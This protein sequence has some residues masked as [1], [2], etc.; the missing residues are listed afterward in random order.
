MTSDPL[1]FFT[2]D[3]GTASTAAALIA[4][5]GGRFRLLASSA[6]PRGLS[7]ETLLEDLVDRVRAAEPDALPDADEWP[8]WARLEVAT[9][10]P[11]RVIVA[12][13]TEAIAD[14]LVRTFRAT[15]WE[16][17]ARFVGG[18]VDP[19]AITRACL[20]RDVSVVV[21]G[22][23]EPANATIRP[24][25]ARLAAA[26]GAAAHRR[27]GLHAILSGGAAAHSEAFPPARVMA[28]PAPDRGHDAGD[29]SLET[30]AAASTTR[31]SPAR[32]RPLPDGR[33]GFA[34]A[35]TSLASLLDRPI[36]ALD[37]GHSAGTR[38]QA[39]P[40]GRRDVHID[41]EAALIPRK[42]MAADSDIDA[43][44][45]WTALRSEHFGM[46]DRLRNLRLAPWRE[47]SDDAARLR[48]AAL[49]SS[50]STLVGHPA[51][52][53]RTGHIAPSTH[54]A[55]AGRSGHA[56]HRGHP[57]GGDL[58]VCAGGVFASIPPPVAALAIL[59]AIRQPGALSI[60]W[61]HARVLA[62]IGTL[63][64]EA[65]RRRL[66]TELLDDVLVPLG[67][68]IV[69]ADVHTGRNSPK[70][71]V[72]SSVGTIETTLEPGHIRTMDLPPGVTGLVELDSRDV[73][74][75]G[76]RGR[77]LVME[78]AGGLGGLLVD[79]REVP[80]R[81]PERAERRRA[82]LESWEHPLWPVP[83]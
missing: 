6:G 83:A 45:R 39:T 31:W 21:L 38:V 47:A 16:I 29:H 72:T 51:P 27:D 63:H 76:V 62:P 40:D 2:I 26:I 5:Y 37:I 43:I 68:A 20:D 52:I 70:L 13:P 11:P 8:S 77:H 56:G 48:L 80:S 44:L 50:L 34:V 64:A 71:R 36:D 1:S 9:D 81:L 78:V 15:G 32:G 35:A 22:A 33:R 46:R 4:P 66:L 17:A 49:R 53:V 79:T 28:A 10:P 74:W 69:V 54:A 7:T 65:D 3:H 24:I 57:I 73:L 61:D 60:L 75:V 67:S 14:D 23:P 58:V 59:D 42:A 82:L 19:M 18:R 30:L 12:A 41:A 25:L 55:D